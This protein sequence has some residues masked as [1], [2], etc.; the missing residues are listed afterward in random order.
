M[1]VSVNTQ[2]NDARR[3]GA[4]AAAVV[5]TL[6]AVLTTVT[7]A[8]SRTVAM[9]TGLTGTG[10]EPARVGIVASV[11]APRA[12]APLPAA[13]PESLRIPALGLDT[14]ALVELG[15]TP[16]GELEVPGT[17][18]AVGWT[19]AAHTPGERGAALLTGHID[20]AYERGAF[21]GLS[22]LTPGSGIVV[23]RADGVEAV[24]TV[25]RVQRLPQETALAAALAPSD[26]P[27]LRLLSA[28]D[29]AGEDTQAVLVTARLTG[30]GG[31]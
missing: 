30:T 14:S 1:S 4:A 11:P 27:D 28:V 2:R 19:P 13:T 31:S 26:E 25:F 17:G 29:A 22:G 15:R 20:V 9:P 23:G 24:F 10:T 16:T 7:L 18:D 5:V 21:F 12:H 8:R 6:A 3:L